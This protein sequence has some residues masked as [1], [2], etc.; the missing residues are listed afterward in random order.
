VIIEP[1]AET[2]RVSDARLLELGSSYGTPLYAYDLQRIDRNARRMRRALSPLRAEF[3]F[4]EFANRNHA[5]LERVRQL[6]FGVTVAQPAGVSRALNCGFGVADIQCSGFG[7]ATEDL[8][9]LLRM[10]VGVNVGSISE[11][12]QVAEFFPDEPVGIRVDFTGSSTDK[13]GIPPDQVLS[14]LR[15]RPLLIRGLHTYIGTNILD[16][17]CHARAC[18]SLTSFLDELPSTELLEYINVGGG[19]GYDYSARRGFDWE[20]YGRAVRPI[21]RAAERSIR[22]PLKL[23]LEVGRALVVDCGY[24]LVRILHGFEKSGRR[25]IVV[26]SNLSHLGRPARYGFDRKFYPFLDDGR[27][28]IALVAA[29]GGPWPG[30]GEEGVRAAVVGNSHYSHDWFGY[31]RLP[32]W[33]PSELCGR[34]AVFLDAGA[35]CEA[36]SDR[37]ADD[38]RPAAAAFDGERDELVTARETIGE[39]ISPVRQVAV[40]ARLP[41]TQTNDM[42]GRS[43]AVPGTPRL[44]RT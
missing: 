32:R 13:R 21:I 35:Y 1:R 41:T 17:D 10:G 12:A 39:L 42:P 37:W 29:G 27:H 24:L 28:E 31:I 7:L 5:I 9:V 34:H 22:K 26:N 4:F 33:E 6:G 16:D 8:G 11:L 2:S 3:H 25:I 14:F 40:P 38:P 20:A 19:F 43:V 30:A 36:M 23:K 18:R 15:S 44:S